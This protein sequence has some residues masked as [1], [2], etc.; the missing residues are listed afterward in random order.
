MKKYVIKAGGAVPH[1]EGE[2]GDESDRS[3][4]CHSPGWEDITGNKKKKEKQAAK[5]KKKADKKKLEVEKKAETEAKH[6]ARMKNRLSK[7]PPTTDR[8]RNMPAMDRSASSPAVQTTPPE[9][10]PKDDGKKSA[11]RSRRGSM[12]LS[13]KNLLHGKKNNHNSASPQPTPSKEAPP[14][15]GNNGFIGG[16]KLRLSEEASNQD[17]IRQSITHDRP[18]IAVVKN[19]TS[20]R[21]P[22]SNSS[23]VNRQ[24]PTAPTSMYVESS[25][26]SAHWDGGRSNTGKFTE[27]DMKSSVPDDGSMMQKKTNTGK[28][29]QSMFPQMATEARDQNSPSSRR[30]AS[31]SSK[32]R[33]PP[34][35][36]R[37]RT[38]GE[39]NNY[40][41]GVSPNSLDRSS[42]NSRDRS[43]D[44]RGR[45]NGSY[46][47]N[48]RLHSKEQA[49]AA[50]KDDYRFKT[51]SEANRERSPSFHSVKSQ[52]SNEAPSKLVTQHISTQAKHL[53]DIES[54]FSFFSD[55]TPPKL[56]LEDHSPSR[57]PVPEMVSSYQTQEA[58]KGL[59]GFAKSVFSK[60]SP[61]ASPARLASPSANSFVSSIFDTVENPASTKRKP[62]TP[63]TD[64]FAGRSSKAD[65]FL[66]EDFPPELQRSA[67]HH[68]PSSHPAWKE[69][70]ARSGSHARTATDSSEEYSTLDEFSNV[71]TPMASRP[72]SQKEYFPPMSSLDPKHAKLFTNGP[73]S[74][75]TSLPHQTQKATM[76]S[77]AIYQDN[78]SNRSQDNFSRT[79]MPMEFVDDE[80][81]TQTP[82][83]HRSL[84]GSPPSPNLAK[85]AEK[86][87]ESKSASALQ[88][89]L[90]LNR[91]ASTPELQDLSF[92]PALKHQALTKPAPKKAKGGILKHLKGKESAQP[93]DPVTRELIRPRPISTASQDSEGPPDSPSS[94]YLRDARLGLPRPPQGV[95]MTGRSSPSTQ[96]A[97]PSATPEPIAKMF[98]VCC[99]CKY[100]HDMPSKIYECM[101]KPDNVVEDKH[102]GVSGVISTSVKCPW[103]GHGMSTTCCAGYAAVVYLRE[104]LH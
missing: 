73:G 76:M 24:R 13:L 19:G 37:P 74:S 66:G 17:R 103:C 30:D 98:V 5:D 10:S 41:R 47:Q 63:V 87:K 44:S 81:R 69:Q 62:G 22:S 72:Q 61:M 91:S 83:G 85:G 54:P 86:P 7:A 56:E 65:R 9:T 42:L 35:S 40:P 99:S 50:F 84:T 67:A 36:S 45:D 96:L 53:G 89:Q 27:V 59:K 52:M 64:T 46:V 20:S 68:G 4:I 101:A 16:L 49:V 1:T 34:S 21:E 93:R 80:E 88:R 82:T 32:N 58:P 39:I 95:G 28:A 57:S 6:A 23:M 8:F 60:Q 92:L 43:S 71:T 14:A 51:S 11:N 102:L 3:S 78:A 79:A 90:S 48:Q 100:F 12:D 94:T 18:S 15:G 75:T 2:S 26:T 104:K 97:H 70:G 31:N 29:R 77:G 38:S 55:Y 25:R 33:Y